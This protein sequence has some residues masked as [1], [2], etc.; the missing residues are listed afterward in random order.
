MTNGTNGARPGAA[1]L[2]EV[3]QLLDDVDAALP[4]AKDDVANLRDRLDQPPTIAVAGRT[5]AGKS[6]LVNALIGARVAATRATECTRVMTWYRYGAEQSRIVRTDGDSV[7][8]YT[9]PAG[10]LPDEL[11]LSLDEVDHADVWLSYAPLRDAV[12]IDTPGL[13]GDDGLADQTER[14]LASGAVDAMIFVLGSAVHA[15]EAKIIADFRSRTAASPVNALGVL[16]RADLYGDGEDP[17]PIAVEAAAKHAM[18]LRTDLAGVVPVMGKIAETTET[19]GFD[20]KQADWLRT[21]AQL[22][23]AQRAKAL[24]WPG[25]LQKLECI[26]AEAH[27]LLLD[28]LGMHGVRLTT[29]PADA[30]ASAA[31]TGRKLRAVSGIA[32][33]RYRVEALFIRPAAIRK[34]ARTLAAVELI[35]AHCPASA[36]AQLYDRLQAIR[37]HR[38]MHVVAELDALAALYSGRLTLCDDHATQM[39][40]RLWEEPTPAGRLMAASEVSRQKLAQRALEASQWWRSYANGAGSAAERELADT[41]HWS[42]YYLYD[43]LRRSS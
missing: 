22:D 40:L 23:E 31:E 19:G 2:S 7:P 18:T 17:W 30:T 14:L 27:S 13:S 28:R 5:N 9:G 15:D 20:E 10:E 38:D 25:T 6:T 11:G 8:L 32:A 16:S 43:N 21:I 4:D 36:R 41:A 39:A 34:A 12:V 37:D 26:P 24:L 1:V 33:L 29:T 35:V 3:R 42:A